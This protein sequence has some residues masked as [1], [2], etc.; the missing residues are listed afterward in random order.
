MTDDR[1]W[2]VVPL[3]ETP[4][5]KRRLAGLLSPAER[6]DLVAAMLADVLTALTPLSVPILVVCSDRTLRP[7]AEAHGTQLLDDP[8]GGL[9]RAAA[10][11]ARWLEHRAARS[12]LLVPGDV[13]ALTAA[14]CS[15]LLAACNTLRTPSVG[16]AADRHARGT[17]ALWCSPPSALP[18][19][20]GLGSAHRHIMAANHV[21]SEALWWRSPGFS[22]DIDT[23][24][25]LCL[26]RHRSTTAAH[27][28]S[29]MHSA[30]LA[31]RLAS[32]RRD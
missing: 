12:M 13:P 14:E 10:A 27:T 23:P 30:G 3:K 20:F 6:G 5:A 29:F 26:L 28:L 8:G 24:E 19:T 4:Q 25:D 7:I 32:H 16:I 2:V 31:E 1:P 11:A 22:L 21:A 17:N 15:R 9:N 18:A